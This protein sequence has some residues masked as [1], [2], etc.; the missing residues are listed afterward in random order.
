V[1]M[2][3]DR[4]EA[5]RLEFEQVFEKAF[6]ETIRADPERTAVWEALADRVWLYDGGVPINVQ[7]VDGRV[8]IWLGENRGEAAG[9]LGSENPAVLDWAE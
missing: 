8:L 5:E 3:R 1:R 6:V 7:I 9:L 2:L 4:F